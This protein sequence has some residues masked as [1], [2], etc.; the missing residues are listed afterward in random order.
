MKIIYKYFGKFS[1]FCYLVFL[2][3]T[4][5]LCQ[6][7]AVRRDLPVWGIS[8]AGFGICFILWLISKRSVQR[9][10]A[11]KKIHKKILY[12]EVLLA[13]AGTLYFGG[14]I[15]YSAIP[16]HG[17]LSWKIDELKRRKKVEFVH[18]NFLENG[19]DGLF[20]DLERAF[21]MPEE[22]YI[23]NSFQMT[24]DESGEI[25]TIDTFLYGRDKK[26]K[27]KTY[28]ITYDRKKDEK[29]I[30]WTGGAANAVYAQDMRLEPMRRI[31]EHADCGQQI[32]SW[33]EQY[34]GEIYEIVYYGRRSFGSADGLKYVAGDVDGDGRTTESSGFEKLSGGGKIAGFELSLHIPDREDLTPVRYI[35]EPEYISQHTLNEKEEET[36]TET[37]KSAESWTVDRNDGTVYFFLDQN[38]GWRLVVTDAAAGS[39]YYELEQTVDGGKAWEKVCENPFDG[40]IGVAEGLV[41]LD[42]K[43]GFAGLSGASGAASGLYR[44][45][46]GGK[47]FSIIRMPV[48]TVTELPSSAKEYGF[49]IED[50]D[51]CEMP[52][53]K[54]DILTVRLL[55]QAGE[56]EG[57]VFVSE[58][59]GETW[60][61]EGVSSEP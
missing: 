9:E 57:I 47:T 7:G 13:I 60:K 45:K 43:S 52:E 27:E 39:R 35:M 10:T 33:S 15:V 42:E 41:F 56:Q 49:T 14:R 6:Y 11:K 20:A 16:Y 53:Q 37:A 8:M 51:Y 44:T 4:W 55:S 25:Q 48:E 54:G 32:R 24:F 58:D 59:H 28:L 17:A 40:N 36:Q 34:S 26:E 61:Y 19:V 2:H 22:L 31:L 21:S 50:Y 12:I 46:D 1:L 3:R 18:D 30:V 5:R 23:S 38:K 29:L